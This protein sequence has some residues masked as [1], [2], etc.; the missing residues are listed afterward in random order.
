MVKGGKVLEV[1]IGTGK[2]MPFYPEGPQFSGIDLTPG[3][4]ERARKRA[5][6][7]GLDLELSLGDVQAL[8]FADASFDTVVASFVFCSV[9]DPR[10]GLRE[11]GRVVKPEG[12][13]L[14]MEHVRSAK[15]LLGSLMDLLN[16]VVVRIVGA[17]INRRTVENARGAGLAIDSVIDLGV[18]DIFKLI[19]AFRG[20]PDSGEAGGSAALRLR[21]DVY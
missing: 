15:P 21:V 9:P 1:G 10:L 5:R 18:G 6:Q 16:P 3:M 11:L 7:L 12:R 20:R 8:D 13:I 2:N 14:L 17:N 19:T 4:L